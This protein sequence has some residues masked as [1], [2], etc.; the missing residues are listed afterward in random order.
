MSCS[1]RWRRQPIDRLQAQGSRV[2]VDPKGADFSRYRGADVITPNRRELAIAAGLPIA[3][4]E[5]AACARALRRAC[6]LRAVLV[7][8]GRDG[9][10][11]IDA[12]GTALPLPAEAH[13][14]FDV[15][16]AGDTVV[17]ILAAALAV[18][19]GTAR[20]G[21][22][23]QRRCRHRRRQSRHRGGARIRAGG[24][25]TQAE[26]C[27]PS[28]R[29]FATWA[30]ASDRVAVWRRQGLSVGFT[31]GCFD[32]IHPGHVSLLAQAKAACDRLVVGLNTDASVAR[33]KG[34]G[35]PVQPEAA[36]AT[37]LASLAAVDVV[38][39]FAEDTPLA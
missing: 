6:G 39:P 2:V 26:R 36:R 10:L 3:P 16:G 20:G 7:T 32:L 13:E 37:V 11:L 28:R 19:R 15:S 12:D 1:A 25:G 22:T 38:V 24:C 21:S 34:S 33:L 29:S 30:T 9:M 27:G 18:G 31:N 8:M 35:R 14:V 5:E 17:A 4:G 23:G